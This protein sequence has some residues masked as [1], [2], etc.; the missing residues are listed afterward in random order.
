MQGRVQDIIFRGTSD[1]IKTCTLENGK[2]PLVNKYLY[3]AYSCRLHLLLISCWSKPLWTKPSAVSYSCNNQCHISSFDQSELLYAANSNYRNLL[4]EVYIYSYLLN[5]LF[6][7]WALWVS[8]G[9]GFFCAWFCSVSP[10]DNK[11]LK[12]NFHKNP[13]P[14]PPPTQDLISNFIMFFWIIWYWIN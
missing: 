9:V 4:Q 2:V 13:P 1:I 7:I 8:K 12:Y 3:S 11:V 14:P 6:Q 10:F 5:G